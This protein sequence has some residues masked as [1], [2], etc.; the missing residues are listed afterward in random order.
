MSSIEN[1]SPQLFTLLRKKYIFLQHGEILKEYPLWHPTNT[2]V[3]FDKLRVKGVKKVLHMNEHFYALSVDIDELETERSLNI[4]LRLFLEDTFYK[5]GANPSEFPSEDFKRRFALFLPTSPDET[6]CH[7][8]FRNGVTGDKY[9]IQPEYLKD[10]L[11][12]GDYVS[13]VVKIE[14]MAQKE[15]DPRQTFWKFQVVQLKHFDREILA[16]LPRNH[17]MYSESST[18]DEDL[19]P[20]TIFFRE[21]DFRNDIVPI[22]A[23][24]QSMVLQNA[25][26]TEPETTE[27]QGTD[28]TETG[29]D[30]RDLTTCSICLTS[31]V[32]R[33]VNCG[34]LFC[35]VC[36]YRLSHCSLCRHP[37]TFRRRIYF[38]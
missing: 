13:L 11:K 25:F 5:S 38:S 30:R 37:I 17:I 7:F 20:D 6:R 28:G 24:L 22:R 4:W 3:I 2:N 12:E 29:E 15:L 33:V 35:Q 34:H 27:A 18:T 1:V 36:V 10:N 32:D 31:M 14:S 19:L 8:T 16:E 26:D 9:I 21:P 23:G